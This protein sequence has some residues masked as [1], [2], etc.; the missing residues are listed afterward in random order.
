MN[1]KEF[2]VHALKVL[3]ARNIFHIPAQYILKRWTICAKDSV[4]EDEHGQKL[5]DQK[6]QPMIFLLKK[7]LDVIYKTSAFE[8][9]QK[10]ATHYLDKASKRVEAVLRAK[11]TDHL[12][13][14]K[15]GLDVSLPNEQDIS[16]FL[17]SSQMDFERVRGGGS[18]GK[19]RELELES[20][21][22]SSSSNDDAEN[23][24]VQKKPRFSENIFEEDNRIPN[25]VS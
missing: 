24:L 2:C 20:G 18:A 9:C 10:I 1:Q 16:L 8:D 11:T 14:R 6:Q 3:N 19:K 15:D 4:A 13:S 25:S 22:A 7:T 5:A 17:T 21:Q 12:K 23:P